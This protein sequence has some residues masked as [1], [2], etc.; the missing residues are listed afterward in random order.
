MAPRNL[1]V[2]L[3]FL[4]TLFSLVAAHEGIGDSAKYPIVVS[5]WPFV[6]AVRAAWKAVDKGFDAVDAV[7]E[8]CSACEEL[9]CDGTGYSLYGFY[10]DVITESEKYRWMGPKRYDYAG[11][12]VFLRHR[13]YEA[14]V[15]YVEV[16][17]EKD[18]S[19]SDGSRMFGTYPSHLSPS[20]QASTWPFVEAL[21][22]AWKAVGK[23]FDAPYK[24][25]SFHPPVN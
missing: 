2:S 7:V 21:R 1:S 22:A 24:A 6:E 11:T 23:G 14:E 19:V 4:F 8:G 16:E 12:K 15:A 18:S 20:N 17:S 3:V 13:S 5:T 9:R 10:G 25:G